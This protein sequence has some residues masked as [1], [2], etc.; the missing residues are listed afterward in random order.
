MQLD[1]AALLEYRQE[2]PYN[3]VLSQSVLQDGIPDYNSLVQDVL[4]QKC[5]LEIVP[6]CVLLSVLRRR[7]LR[8][9]N[10]IFP[11]KNFPKNSDFHSEKLRKFL[12]SIG[13][14][15]LV[16]VFAQNR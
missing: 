3:N 14:I 6:I 4:L 8:F 13:D 11:P 12:S 16:F 7:K 9:Q 1:I 15:S 2:C 10:P 5:P